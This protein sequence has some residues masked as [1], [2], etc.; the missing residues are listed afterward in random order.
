MPIGDGRGDANK[1]RI[2]QEWELVPVLHTRLLKGQRIECCCGDPVGSTYYRFDAM[3]R[4]N[5]KRDVLL[6]HAEGCARKLLR[7]VPA[8][9]PIPL[10]D[11]LRGV[12]TGSPARGDAGGGG[13]GPRMHPF[14][15]E[16]YEVIHLLLMCW[17][18]APKSGGALSVILA[19]IRRAPDWPQP[20]RNA[21]SV[22]TA[23]KSGKRT[24]TAMLQALPPQHPPMREFEFPRMREALLKH[25]DKP[26]IWL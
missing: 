23:I 9:A 21:K 16:L 13:H 24:L 17:D 18:D 20:E 22:N 26:D 25:P 1:A 4:I 12:T 14:N 6:A 2:R 15:R 8:I 3:H 11:P 10:F 5:G 19:D 7:I